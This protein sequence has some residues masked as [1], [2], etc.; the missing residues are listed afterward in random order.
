MLD[1]TMISALSFKYGRDGRISSVRVS[2]TEEPEDDVT[3]GKEFLSELRNYNV[4]VNERQ[5]EYFYIIAR[6]IQLKNEYGKVKSLD[7]QRCHYSFSSKGHPFCEIFVE[8]L[9]SVLSKTTID[10]VINFFNDDAKIDDL[11]LFLNR[12][13]S[14]QIALYIMDGREY[15]LDNGCNYRAYVNSCKSGEDSYD[16]ESFG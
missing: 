10:S 6:A 8:R 7:G 12:M 16:D 14:Y 15:N 5:K 11:D 1:N 9:M 2:F 13:D 3:I 4:D